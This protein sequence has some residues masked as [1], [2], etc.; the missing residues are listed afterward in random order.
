M[1]CTVN[2]KIGNLIIKLFYLWLWTTGQPT[3]ESI[4]LITFSS[5]SADDRNKEDVPSLTLGLR[6]RVKHLHPLPPLQPLHPQPVHLLLWH[7]L[8]HSLEEPVS[9]L[10]MSWLL[11]L[12]PSPLPP[13]SPS[14]HTSLLSSPRRWTA[15]DTAPA[16]HNHDHSPAQQN[17]YQ[18]YCREGLK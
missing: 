4:C 13:Y 18:E 9:L 17:N 12:S 10:Q 2:R 15:Q 5:T 14:G 8:P 11:P 16:L 6:I 3:Q 7:H 1:L